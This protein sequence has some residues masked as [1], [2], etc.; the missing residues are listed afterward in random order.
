MLPKHALYQTELYPDFENEE[1]ILYP[2]IRE[3]AS[4]NGKKDARNDTFRLLFRRKR[5][6][7]FYYNLNLTPGKIGRAH[8]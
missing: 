8:V 6:I 4:R 7:L 3:K 5:C 1:I 2:R